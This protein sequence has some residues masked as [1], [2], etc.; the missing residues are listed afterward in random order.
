MTYHSQSI[1]TGVSTAA[2]CDLAIQ[3]A[4]DEGHHFFFLFASFVSIKNH[5]KVIRFVGLLLLLLLLLLSPIMAT[6]YVAGTPS[7]MTN[8]PSPFVSVSALLPTIQTDGSGI[9]AFVTMI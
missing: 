8:I 1:L 9:E 4:S 7:D 5:V 6:P 3:E 2:G